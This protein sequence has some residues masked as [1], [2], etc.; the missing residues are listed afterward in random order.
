MPKKTKWQKKLA[1]SRRQTVLTL[2]STNLP[3]LPQSEKS[4]ILNKTISPIQL[5]SE[6]KEAF[7]GYESQLRLYTFSDLKK[8]G[9]IMIFLFALEFMFFY[10]KLKGILL[11]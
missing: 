7:S 5:S 10:A 6:P 2:D 4:P 11:K 1:D 8:T 9:I 3:P